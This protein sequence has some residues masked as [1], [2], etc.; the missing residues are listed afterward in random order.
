MRK[1]LCSF[2]ILYLSF[3]SSIAFAGNSE[4]GYIFPVKGE[5]RIL[6]VFAE[7]DEISCYSLGYNSL[8]HPKTCQDWPS[9]TLP[10]NLAISSDNWWFDDEYI[11]GQ[12]PQ[13]EYS[14]Y[15]YDM[16][17]GEYNVVA[18]YYPELV[19]VPCALI[20]TSVEFEQKVFDYINMSG[21]PKQT[22]AG[23]D[24]SYFDTW[25]IT[26]KI[27]DTLLNVSDGIID[28]CI[29]VWRNWN[30]GK[31]SK[32][33]DDTGFGIN[34]GLFKKYSISSVNLKLS[35]GANYRSCSGSPDFALK[36]YFHGMFGGNN[37]HTAGGAG[38][39][40]FMATPMS[41]SMT[42]Q[43]GVSSMACG[44]DRYRLGYKGTPEY[45]TL[46]NNSIVKNYPI[47]ALNS[48]GSAEVS[49]DVNILNNPG[50]SVFLLRDF[51]LT[52]DALRIKLPIVGGGVEEEQYL[53]IE[54]HQ[55]PNNRYSRFD[56]PQNGIDCRSGHTPVAGIYSYIQVGK[57]DKSSFDGLGDYLFP[58]P[59]EG[60]YDFYYRYDKMLPEASYV[61]LGCAYGHA[62]V[63]YDKSA[64]LQNPFTGLSDLFYIT[65]NDNQNGANNSAGF[66]SQG[67][68]ILLD[69]QNSNYTSD[70]NK[71][72]YKMQLAMSEVV[73][74]NLEFHWQG[75]G[76]EMDAFP[77]G[78]KIGIG[79]NPASTPVYTYFTMK[80][81]YPIP[82]TEYD[83]SLTGY[84][85]ALCKENRHIWLN[86][87]SVNIE[88]AVNY[89]PLLGNVYLVRVKWDDYLLDGSM[90][91][92]G[93]IVLRNITEDPLLRQNKVKLNNGVQLLLDQGFSPTEQY[94]KQ[95]YNEGGVNKHLFADPT[96]MLLENGTKMEM[97][98]SSELRVKNGS[99]Y[100]LQNDA[101]L[102]MGANSVLNIEPTGFLCVDDPA[103][104]IFSGTG[105]TIN[106]KGSVFYPDL[107]YVNTNIP[108][109]EHNA[110][111]QINT[112]NNV[113]L[114]NNSNTTLRAGISVKLQP[115]FKTSNLGTGT[116]VAK[117]DFP[118]DCQAQSFFCG[119]VNGQMY[120]PVYS[121]TNEIEEEMH[122]HEYQS[123]IE[124]N[125]KV[126]T[127]LTMYPNPSNGKLKLESD[128]KIINVTIYD[129]EGRRII[130]KQSVMN[131]LL[132]NT[133]ELKMGVYFI[134]VKMEDGET[135]NDSFLVTQ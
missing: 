125:E 95:L 127:S 77:E 22:K 55:N 65:D 53:W 36:E 14:K 81:E 70:D 134:S 60:R 7:L 40:T 74:N 123:N 23:H 75:N 79:T 90:R 66:L 8:I 99:T 2:C 26:G 80:D 45:R 52:G 67:N 111:H 44:W 106:Y 78:S 20:G 107:N 11:P 87:L 110:V 117:I 59:Y 113:G 100:H 109:G 47:S 124:I 116:F 133:E 32:D 3:L 19:K 112:S 12:V 119:Q 64:S 15:F 31:W 49:T 115:G 17:M 76:D 4:N 131:N 39:M 24:L 82:N 105:A 97:A 57:E 51:R 92:A 128:K 122:S 43:L 120:S 1:Y 86:G 18:D 93:N 34:Y 69:G 6:F 132:I 41:F 89:G 118:K 37:F 135:I 108:S 68:G 84:T 73:N 30:H 28:V 63:P 56:L 48:S 88:S 101:V 5:M 16:S 42:N 114:I 61:N 46:N 94:S 104:I 54:N 21:T 71:F 33:A 85:T 25:T 121:T 27:G 58:L 29:V 130:E 103:D 126:L 129:A 102:E 50:E 72:E 10:H 98:S 91:W 9:G 96:I 35:T 38:N 83:P 13:K 62:S